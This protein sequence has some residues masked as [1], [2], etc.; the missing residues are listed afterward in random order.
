MR[1]VEGSALLWAV[2]VLAVMLIVISGILALSESY[3]QSESNEIAQAQAFSYASAGIELTS[4]EIVSAGEASD[5]IPR[6]QGRREAVIEMET[7]SCTVKIYHNAQ[8]ERLE[9][10]ASATVGEITETV[11]A[12]M[13]SADGGF[14]PAVFTG[15]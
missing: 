14:S 5:L 2:G 7:A 10:S 15:N 11:S 8:E 4:A 6:P 9:L 13:Q 12:V 1:R 3:A